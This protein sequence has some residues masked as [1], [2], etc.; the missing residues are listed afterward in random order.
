[1][2]LAEKIAFVTGAAAGIGRAV[3]TELVQRK[4]FVL[5]ADID[6]EAVRTLVT[7]L[8]N[9]TALVLDVTEESAWLSAFRTIDHLDIFIFG[10]WHF[11]R[12]A[13]GRHDLG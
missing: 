3:V 10:S 11:S 8:S 7:Q 6:R 13:R 4:A 1:M 9:T 2:C 12:K 5:A